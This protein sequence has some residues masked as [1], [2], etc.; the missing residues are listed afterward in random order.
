MKIE[1]ENKGKR[2][3]KL[4][5]AIRTWNLHN[6]QPEWTQILVHSFINKPLRARSKQT[7]RIQRRYI[8]KRACFSRLFQKLGHISH[9]PHLSLTWRIF[10]TK[11]KKSQNF[12]LHKR[13]SSHF[14]KSQPKG[15]KEKEKG[16]QRK[17]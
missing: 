1:Q 9:S 3:T 17:G 16:I 15:K 5:K 8:D 13:S 10:Q 2:M 6:L 4:S 11:K 12:P 7:N 14:T